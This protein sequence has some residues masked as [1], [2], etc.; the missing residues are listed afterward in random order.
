MKTHIR[1]W[2]NSLALRLPKEA[3]AQLKLTDGS[4]IELVI[5]EQELVITPLSGPTSLEQL[6]THITPSN[7]HTETHIGPAR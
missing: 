5:N 4:E 1:Q 2:G 6:I 7:R 3:A